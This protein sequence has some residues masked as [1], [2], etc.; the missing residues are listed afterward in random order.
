M[1][2]RVLLAL[3]L[4][5][6][7]HIAGAQWIP[8]GV[9][10]CTVSGE[11]RNPLMTSDGAGGAIVGWRDQRNGNEDV[12]VQR[13]SNTGAVLWA[14]DGAPVCVALGDQSEPNL[15][16]DGSNGAILVWFDARD[17]DNDIYAQ[18]L[19]ANGNPLWT[20]NGVPLDTLAG[21]QRKNVRGPIV[22]DGAGGAIVVW[23]EFGSSS[24]RVRAQRINSQGV[25]QWANNGVEV[26]P[27]ALGS[28]GNPV[29]LEDGAGGAFVIWTDSRNGNND[30]Y[31]QRLNSLGVPQWFTGPDNGIA[32]CTA[33]NVQRLPVVAADGTG[34]FV[35]AWEDLRNPGQSRA[36]TQRVNSAGVVQWTADGVPVGDATHA[37]T[38]I[39][40]AGDETG[41]WLLAWKDDNPPF[42]GV[43]DV[44][45]QRLNSSGAPVW[46]AG[47]VGVC[48]ADD[49]QEDPKIVADG[50]GG[51]YV[52]WFDQ[53]D[54]QRWHIYSQ[55]LTETGQFYWDIDGV[56]TCDEIGDQVQ[57]SLIAT[58]DGGAIAAW[59][60]NRDATQFDIYASLLGDVPNAVAITSFEATLEDGVVVLRSAFRS[61]LD[62]QA[63]NVYRAAGT[64]ALLPI[65]RVGDAGGGIFTYEDARVTPGETYRYQIGVIDVD[66]EFYSPVATVTVNTI[67]LAL[68]QNRPNPFN[69]TTTIHFV[70]PIREHATLAVYDTSGRKVRTLLDEMSEHGGHDVL[71]DGRDDAGAAVGSGVYFYRL[72]AGKRTESKKMI[73]LK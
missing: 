60:D 39:V 47:G 7:P 45:A 10:L 33:A 15:I 25:V 57:P 29:V 13:I 46:A 27:H 73:L 26:S 20:M 64:G 52:T 12:Y 23:F 31:A 58:G 40:I 53:R 9:P 21:D 3:C 11:Q 51:G 36:Y 8:Q 61:D 37:Q 22:P 72:T 16:S 62:V 50:N 55:R 14:A 30:I 42:D 44:Y 4:V 34:G 32:V 67:A 5:L 19:D 49:H 2:C 48:T 28:Q 6:L 71:W 70:L 63:V 56:P 66:G 41:G 43:Y 18:R 65:E 38:A 35:V 54:G 17:G 1:N 59:Y 24:S 68:D 69:P